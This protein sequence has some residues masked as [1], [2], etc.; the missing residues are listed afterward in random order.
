MDGFAYEKRFINFLKIF[1]FLVF[2][3]SFEQLFE[4]WFKFLH[5]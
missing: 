4:M 1:F 5:I 3:A 2:V